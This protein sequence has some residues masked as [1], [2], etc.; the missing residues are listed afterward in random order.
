MRQPVH[1]DDLAEAVAR[2]QASPSLPQQVYVLAGGEQLTY[3]RMIEHVFHS[4]RRKVR[5]WIIPEGLFKFAVAT[6][7]WLPGL[8]F[9]NSEMITRME[10]DLVYDIEPARRDF[11]YSPGMFR[12]D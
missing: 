4:Q 1:V 3:R 11:A 2:L 6:L 9:L 10:Q 5:F 8:R 7:S 12:P